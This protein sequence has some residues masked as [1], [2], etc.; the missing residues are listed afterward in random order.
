MA[1]GGA[2]RE[3]WSGWGCR[4]RR[5]IGRATSSRILISRQSGGLL[6]IRLPDGRPAKTPALPISID[7]ERLGNHRDPPRLGE[8]TREVLTDLGYR[9]AEIT[10]LAEA[11]VVGT[12]A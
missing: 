7:G 1:G 3:R 2:R 10:A 12:S 11:G 5:S 9:E 4:S 6:D 8:H